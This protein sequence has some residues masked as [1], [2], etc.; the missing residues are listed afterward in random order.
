MNDF[1]NAMKKITDVLYGAA[2][3]SGEILDNTKKAYN[4]SAEKDK[5]AKVQ[6]QIGLK[7]YKAYLAGGDTPDYVQP[8]I[9]AIKVIDERIQELERSMAESKSCKICKECGA[10]IALDDVYCPKCGEK[11]PNQPASCCEPASEDESD[12]CCDEAKADENGECAEP[13]Q[14]EEAG[15]CEEDDGF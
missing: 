4:I 13:A 11:Q 3:K 9:E 15:C 8:E 12:A 10:R 5:I 14:Q 6:S 7:V 1:E 2:R